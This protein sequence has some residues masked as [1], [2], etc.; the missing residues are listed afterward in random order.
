MRYRIIILI[1][2]VSLD[3]IVFAQGNST[4]PYS[5]YGIGDLAVKGFGQN[6]AMGG[7]AIG[8]RNP[9]HLNLVNPAS[10]TACDSLSFVFENG[11]SEKNTRYE[12]Y[13]LKKMT[14]Q[15]NYSYLAIGFPVSRVWSFGAALL[16]YS[17]VG[18][19]I[20]TDSSY[21]SAGDTV[22]TVKSYSGDG[23]LNQFVIGT[24]LKFY[25]HLSVG[26][27]ASYLFGYLGYTNIINFLNSSGVVDENSY[28]IQHINKISVNDFSL[29]Y[30]IQYFN[31]L[32]KDIEYTIGLTFE[33]RNKINAS[34]NLL[35]LRANKYVTDTLPSSVDKKDYLVLPVSYGIGISLKTDRLLFAADY[36]AQD[37]SES[38]FLGNRDSLSN[39]NRCSFG[40]QFLP[41]DR[42]INNYLKRIRYRIG[43]HYSNTYLNLRSEQL[44][45]YSISFGLGFPIR[46]SRTSL[47]ISFEMG[48]RGTTN[49]QLILENYSILHIN[50]SLHDFWFI[51]RK[52]D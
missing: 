22:N 9:Y 31:N 49:H 48:R 1:C 18:Y 46:R 51:H 38:T 6:I 26:I 16:P 13:N 7:S 45:D 5:R 37:W 2:L 14:D 3:I 27:N 33:G 42:E 41:N 40:I 34:R 23:G 12:T 44:K 21:Y 4:S 24:S 29:S 10:Y 20:Y 47:N 30:G 17:S 19:N 25:N 52:F 28:N 35:V 15:L 11:I 32:N 39:S 36:S 43:G 8:L 50:L